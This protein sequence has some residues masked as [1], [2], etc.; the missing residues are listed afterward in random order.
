M[1]C[2][3]KIGDIINQPDRFRDEVKSAQVI[4]LLYGLPDNNSI[5]SMSTKWMERIEKENPNVKIKINSA[6]R[7][8]RKLNNP[9]E[10]TP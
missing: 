9:R 2:Y 8:Q 7:Y 1:C 10:D 3:I 4:L 6:Q 5:Q